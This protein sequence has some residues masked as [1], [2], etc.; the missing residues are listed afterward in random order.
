MN[1]SFSRRLLA[2]TLFA[3]LIGA[4]ACGQ[5]EAPEGTEADSAAMT[6]EDVNAADQGA[7]VAFI[8]SMIPHHAMGIHMADMEMEHG[9]RQEVKDIA[10]KIK[11][12]QAQD[13]DQMKS[14]RR[15]LAGSDSVAT[16]GMMMGMSQATMD[17]MMAMHGTEMDQAFLRHMIHHHEQGLNMARR[18][19]PDLTHPDLQALAQKMMTTQEQEIG[20]MRRLQ[21]Q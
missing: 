10:Q 13:T 7:N 18:A 1:A 11:D 21:G 16:S 12:G 9:E 3:L 20:E 15:E 14:I 5:D 17:S 8:D 4:T 19:Q 2:P 6:M